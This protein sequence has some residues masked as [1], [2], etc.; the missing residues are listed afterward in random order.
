MEVAISNMQTLFVAPVRYEVPPFQRAYIWN[1]EKQWDP[2]WEDIANM[3]EDILEHNSI[4]S[5]PPG[6]FLGA[7]VLQQKRVP[8]PMFQHRIVVDGQQRLITLQILLNAVGNVFEENG[9]KKASSR[10]YELVINSEHRRGSDPDNRFKVWPTTT[11]Q[12]AFR[13]AMS[14]ESKFNKYDNKTNEISPIIEAHDYFKTQIR[15]WLNDQPKGRSEALEQTVTQL[16]ELVVIDLGESDNPHVIFETLNARGTPLL[17][18]DLVKNMILYEANKHTSY[19]EVKNLDQ[20]WSFQNNWW[21]KEI[22]QGR[23]FRPRVDVFLYYWLVM[24]KVDGFAP[25]RLFS[26]FRKYSDD[27]D[28]TKVAADLNNI[29]KLYKKYETYPEQYIKKFRYHMTT[30]Q[31]GALNPVI[32]W[33]LSEEISEDQLLIGLEALESHQI[34]RMVCR[35][36]T[37]GYTR[38]FVNLLKELSGEPE[39]SGDIIREYLMNQDSNVG[40]WPSDEEFENCFINFP[41]YQ[42]LTRGRLRII[43][44]SIEEALRTTKAE[45]QSV[46]TGLTIEHIMPQ[47]WQRHWQTLPS[48]LDNAEENRNRVIH[49]IGNLTLVNNRLNSDLSNAPWKE[50]KRY[51]IN[52]VPCSLTRICG[53][54]LPM[55]GTKTRLGIELSSYVK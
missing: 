36:N 49:T 21:R 13:Q 34:R 35:M 5:K 25:E 46:P 12:S 10:L 47:L 39:N 44:E 48:D 9:D 19:Q 51:S 22:R 2:L 23:I 30:M 32:L 52:I 40:L 26:E 50:R 27:K 45:T 29:G 1:K 20:L 41:L 8:T 55:N 16:L 42:Q 6:H 33:L 38:L 3:A 43:M 17:Q 28:I 24:R 4:E 53:I 37:R 54:I 7:V 18:S 31:V 11:D 15:F 14:D